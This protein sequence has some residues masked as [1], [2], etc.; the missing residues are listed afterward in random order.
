MAPTYSL[1]PYELVF[2]VLVKS[3]LHVTQGE[4]STTNGY[5]IFYLQWY[6]V[7]KICWC[8]SDT[9]PVGLT[10]QYLV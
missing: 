7:F 2:M 1:H 3:I 9:K 10:N 8:N 6:P 4:R 5:K